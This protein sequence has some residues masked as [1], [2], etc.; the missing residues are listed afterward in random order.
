LRLLSKELWLLYKVL[1]LVP[2]PTEVSLLAYCGCRLG[3]VWSARKTLEA[4]KAS[5]GYS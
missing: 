2:H 3:G 1:L 5:R 4:W